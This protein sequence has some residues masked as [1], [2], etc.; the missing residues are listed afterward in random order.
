M[1]HHT[2]ITP[3]GNRVFNTRVLNWNRVYETRDATLQ[4]SFKHILTYDILPPHCA[5]LH[6]PSSYFWAWFGGDGG[7]KSV[8]NLSKK[9]RYDLG[10]GDFLF[11][12]AGDVHR[13]KYYEDTEFFIRWDGKWDMFFDEDLKT[14]K[15]AV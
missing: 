14:A 3:S 10:V 2:A 13:V 12:P 5:S 6:I 4:L 15:A 7:K 1:W 11:T 8:W 9:E